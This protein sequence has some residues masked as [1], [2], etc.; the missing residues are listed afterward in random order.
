[1]PSFLAA[2]LGGGGGSPVSGPRNEVE[3]DKS[4]PFPLPVP[5]I[6]SSKLLASDS[7]RGYES[8]ISEA[9]NAGAGPT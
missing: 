6:A 7:L 5:S 8:H 3:R 9:K 1:M 2:D 4:A